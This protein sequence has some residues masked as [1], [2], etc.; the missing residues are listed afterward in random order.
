MDRLTIP[1][2]H[3][4]S[5]ILF[6]PSSNLEPPENAMTND[7]PDPKSELKGV[8]ESLKLDP[9]RKTRLAQLFMHNPAFAETFFEARMGQSTMSCTCIVS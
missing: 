3:L 7:T 9:A 6:F 5:S 2:S 4:L 1:H 8:H